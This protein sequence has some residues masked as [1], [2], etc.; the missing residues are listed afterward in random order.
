M[1]EW[2]NIQL[3]KSLIRKVKLRRILLVK[4]WHVSSRMVDGVWC[5]LI[6]E[7]D[8]N[9]MCYSKIDFSAEKH[10]WFYCAVFFSHTELRNT[11]WK[12]ENCHLL[13]YSAVCSVYK[14]TLR[15]P[16]HYIFR[17]EKSKEGQRRGSKRKINCVTCFPLSACLDLIS[18]LKMEILLSSE[19]MAKEQPPKSQARQ[20]RRHFKQS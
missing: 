12:L 2:E 15:I 8:A 17:K 3:I 14:R 1:S 11:T 16:F 19:I 7:L 18:V 10:F 5:K 13:G 6:F 4:H 20:W 9:S